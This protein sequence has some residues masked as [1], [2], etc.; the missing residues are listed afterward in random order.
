MSTKAAE[1]LHGPGT[2]VR[3]Q[4]DGDPAQGGASRLD[5][6]VDL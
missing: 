6:Q 5:V 3:A 2:D 1:I 4:G